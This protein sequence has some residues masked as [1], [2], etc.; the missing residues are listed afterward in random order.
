MLKLLSRAVSPM[1][2][3]GALTLATS[4]SAQ[5][6]GTFT[7][8][9]QPYCNVLTLT[10]TQ[11]AG[12][13]TLDGYDDQCGS[14][15]RASAAGLGFLNPD[16]TIGLGLAIVVS[17]DAAP[18]HVSAAITPGLSGTWRDSSGNT[19][20]LAFSPGSAAG[21]PR[22]PPTPVFVGG[23]SA[24]GG[25]ITNVAPPISATD[26]ATKG[27]ADS[28]V[29]G[30]ALPPASRFIFQPDGGFAALTSGIGTIPASGGGDRLLWHPAKAALRAGRVVGT[31]WND[32][33]IGT[34]SVALGNS[35]MAS[36]LVST[37]L[38]FGTTA[39]GAG[40]TAFGSSTTASGNFSTAGGFDTGATGVAATALGNSATASGVSSTAMGQDV[41][42]SGDYSTAIG[43]QTAASGFAST[44]IGQNASTDGRFGA[45]VYGD[46]STTS[47]VNASANNQFTVRAT[48]GFRFFS[49][50]G[51]TAG[52]QLVAGAS[53]W[54]TVSD[55]NS[56]Q[57]FRDLDG[58][59]VL[60]K[61]AAIPI[62]EWSYKAQDAAI[63]HVGP[64]AQDFHAAFGLG[65]DP[66]G[67]S[68]IDADG[69]A[70]RAIQALEAR[71]G[72]QIAALEAENRMLRSQL[73]ALT[74]AIA[75]AIGREP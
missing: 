4:A 65:E 40:S 5:P 26:A 69:I 45:F 24:G 43:R 13:Y 11:T 14:A 18:V 56:K 51:L 48:G 58:E 74:R 6:I 38:G 27:Y 53:A 66:L 34:N 30:A 28:L 15:T 50:T 20:T 10:I 62:R 42:A 67:I 3:A 37:A 52:V 9:L 2:L 71:T 63:R 54:T 68:T 1:M 46:A 32:V 22:P 7:W 47:V 64:T 33:N 21:S 39:S 60:S 12:I 36:G 44:A 19:G 72:K 55:V 29:A 17:P 31:Q 59:T 57:L 75:T 25:T 41:T 70:L 61:L 49:N 73:D 16:G 23:L 35:T 8:Q